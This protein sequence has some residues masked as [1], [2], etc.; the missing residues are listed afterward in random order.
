MDMGVRGRICDAHRYR[1]RGL[2]FLGGRE[3]GVFGKS[4]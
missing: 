4:C 2:I 3:L 1:G